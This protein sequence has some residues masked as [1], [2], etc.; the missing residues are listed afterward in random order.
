MLIRPLRPDDDADRI[1][2]IVAD[3]YLALDGYPGGDG[4]E[5]TLRNV[6]GRA[7]HGVSVMVA[8]LDGDVVG[9]VTFIGDPQSEHAEHGDGE[10]SS[11]R[12]FGVDGAVQGRGVG[13]AIV[14]WCI[15][16]S[17]RLGRRRIRIHTLTMMTGAQRLYE[18]LGFLRDPVFDADWD[19][20]VGL[21]YRREL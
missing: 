10:A 9:C 5:A 20:V 14:R 13:E 15:D 21:A 18:R 2:G 11:F 7:A 3:A 6:L 19:G 1:G 17:R 16:E 12:Y 8:E 4:Y